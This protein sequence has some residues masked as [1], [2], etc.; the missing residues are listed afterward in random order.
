MHDATDPIHVFA[1]AL[2]A[3]RFAVKYDDAIK[4]CGNDPDKM[5]TYCTAQGESLDHLYT[6]WQTEAKRAI[7]LAEQHAPQLTALPGL[8]AD[9]SCAIG[10][11]RIEAQSHR[12]NQHT[13]KAVPLE[14]FIDSFKATLDKL[15]GE[16]HDSDAPSS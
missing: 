9:C 5:S 1:T 13:G 3:C 6:Q 2:N 10:L 16:S 15:T 8:I 12:E 7:E 11:L 4:S 14:Q